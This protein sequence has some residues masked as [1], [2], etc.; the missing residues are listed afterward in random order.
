MALPDHVPHYTI[1]DYQQWEG[2]WE[3]WYGIPVALGDRSAKAM[4]PSPF[5]KHQWLA[6]QLAFKLNSQLQKIGCDECFVLQELDWVI[7]EDLVVRP[8]ISLVCGEFPEEFLR[9][10]PALVVEVLSNS[11]EARD[12]ESKKVLYQQQRVKHYVLVNPTTWTLQIFSLNEQGE[13][14]TIPTTSKLELHDRCCVGIEMPPK[15]HG[16]INK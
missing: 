7:S 12:S 13:Y 2:D 11:T 5:G 16:T 15:P 4:T 10:P 14:A 8:D 1:E 9:N 6:G 3:L